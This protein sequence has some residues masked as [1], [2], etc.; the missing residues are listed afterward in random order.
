MILKLKMKGLEM[1]NILI[2]EDNK[3][4]AL[5]MKKYLSKNGYNV[6]LSSFL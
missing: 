5:Q 2:I 3:E 4:I 6:E 1:K